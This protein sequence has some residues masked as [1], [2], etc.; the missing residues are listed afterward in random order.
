MILTL[1]PMAVT[2]VIGAV[3]TYRFILYTDYLALLLLPLAVEGFVY[4]VATDPLPEM[5]KREDER[6][7]SSIH[8]FE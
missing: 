5:H 1:L 8:I 7:H 3:F 6:L 4:I 2:A